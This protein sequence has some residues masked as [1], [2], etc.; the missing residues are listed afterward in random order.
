MSR[1]SDSVVPFPLD[2]FVNVMKPKQMTSSDVVCI[3]RGA[4]SAASGCRRKAGH[5][6]TL[7]PL[8]T[9][10]LPVAVGKA[11]RLFDLLAFKRKTYVAEFTFGRTTDTLDS[12]GTFSEERGNV[13]DEKEIREALPS[14]VGKISQIP[15]AYSS[16]SVDGRRAYSYARKG[17][18]IQ[19]PPKT[20]QVYSFE[21]TGRKGEAF[22]FE[23]ECGGGTYIRS[24][25][26]DL[27]AALGTVGYMSALERTRSGVFTVD[28]A[29]EIEDFRR[30]PLDY[31]LPMQIALSQF[32]RYTLNDGETKR[33]LNGIA[34]PFCD[35]RLTYPE[36][37]GNSAQS[38]DAFVVY[39]TSD[40]PLGIGTIHDGKLKLKTR[41]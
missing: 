10:V 11:T 13:P 7:D 21:L 25:A 3:V 22:E 20:V 31:V 29:V 40:N 39:Y 4:L 16:K 26:R 5:L 41:L 33:A 27:A 14:F 17:V 8:A 32:G 23:I 18:E 37:N 6:G 12:G 36:A 24:L 1:F 9:G 34:V 35:E 38:D 30:A 28:T 2:G 15:P 19:L